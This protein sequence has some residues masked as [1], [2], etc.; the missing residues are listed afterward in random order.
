MDNNSSNYNKYKISIADDDVHNVISDH[1][2]GNNKNKDCDSYC[3][4]LSDSETKTIEIKDFS[5]REVCYYKMIDKY[6][7]Q[8]TVEKI[9]KMVNIINKDSEISLRILDWFVTRYSQKYNIYYKI[10]NDVDDF[11]VHI[12]YKA[13]LKSF[14]KRYFDPFR[15]RKKFYYYY[16]TQNNEKKSI[17]TTIGQMNFFKWA[18]DH[19]VIEYVE[20]RHHIISKAMNKANKEDKKRKKNKTTKSFSSSKSSKSKYSHSTDKKEDDELSIFLSFD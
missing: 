10:N 18:F 15:R 8:C 9:E 3:S 6:F 14:K 4:I 2:G 12:S 19:K 11:N 13:Q 5:S 7:K 1:Y 17:L 20:E 16:N